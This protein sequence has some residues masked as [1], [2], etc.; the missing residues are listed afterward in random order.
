MKNIAI[1][2][3]G[4]SGLMIAVRLKNNKQFNITIFDK[5][6]AVG[7]KLLVTGNGRCNVT[8]LCSPSQFLEY[9]PHNSKFLFS[10]INNFT[11]NDMVEFLHDNNQEVIVVEN[12]RVFPTSNKAESIRAMF[13]SLVCSADNITLKLNTNVDAIKYSNNTLSLLVGGK[14][15]TF[16]AVVVATGGLSYPKTGS[17]GDGIAFASA[18]NLPLTVARPALC[19]IKLKNKHL[20]LSGNSYNVKL[21]LCASKVTG[22]MLF[23]HFGVSGPAV[24]ELTSRLQQNSIKDSE[25][26]V[27]FMPDKTTDELNKM[28]RQYYL[29]NSKKMLKSCVA[30]FVGEKL[31]KIILHY[32]NLDETIKVANISTKQT[33]QIINAIKNYNLQVLDFEDIEHATITRGGVDVNCINSKT[34]ESKLI[35]NLYFVGEV[36]DVDGLSGGFNLQI[37]FSTAVACA[38]AIVKR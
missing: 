4:A 18:L 6:L 29:D 14:T 34:M 19:G 17:T 8:N 37:A 3:A 13:E 11:P 5:N 20:V 28:F 10:A 35:P 23:T 31:A 16:D 22:N 9:V 25:L 27:D 2:G 15:Q 30:N 32:C 26:I 21:Q 12:N 33:N 24:F 7:K 38:D 1:I 36:L